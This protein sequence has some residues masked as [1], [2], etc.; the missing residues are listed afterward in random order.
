MPTKYLIAAALFLPLYVGAKE[1]PP[2]QAQTA[3]DSW[4]TLPLAELHPTQPAVGMLRVEDTIQ[5]LRGKSTAALQK[6]AKKK[7]IVVVIGPNG[8]FYLADRHH[9]SRSLFDLGLEQAPV[10]IIGKLDNP[11]TF[12][13]DM[14]KNNWAYPV[15]EHG[16][17]ID[18]NQLPKTLAE[19]KNDP[20]RSLAAYAQEDG[21]YGKAQNA[22]FIE[23]A[24][25]TYFGNAMQWRP[26]TRN[27][28]HSA[29]N[30]AKILACKPAAKPL[31]G[32]KAECDLVSQ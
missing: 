16:K 27:N 30:E 3:V 4:C 28:L 12:W 6:Y 20:Y 22:Y 13:T 25:S 2:C 23:F 5:K 15:D 21:A 32:Y 19:L 7:T 17:E 8:E 29:I 24:W 14:R 26:I 11:A 10:K 31:P 18:P 1:L 9:L